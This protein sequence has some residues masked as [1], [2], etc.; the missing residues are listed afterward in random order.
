MRSSIALPIACVRLTDVQLAQD[1]L[2]VVLHGQRADLEDRA[3]LEVALAE[4]DPV[5]DFHA[6][7]TV[8]MLAAQ[9]ASR[10]RSPAPLICAA[11]PGR[12]QQR[13]DQLHEVRLARPDRSRST[14][15]GEKLVTLPSMSCSPVHQQPGR[16][17]ALELPS[18]GAAGERTSV[19]TSQITGRKRC[20]SQALTRRRRNASVAQEQLAEDR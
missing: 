7:A 6:R 20:S 15:E 10:C 13:R 3:D 4:V 8:S 16:P 14:G 9:R 5:Q 18:E 19:D 17:D 1:L 2:H 12:V 11:H